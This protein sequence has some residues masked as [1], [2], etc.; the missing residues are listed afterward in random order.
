MNK[1]IFGNGGITGISD[2]KFS[3][4]RG[5]AHRLVG[6]DY[7][8]EPGIVKVQQAL[9]DTS[10]LNEFCKIGVN[11]PDNSRLWFSSTS[12]KIWRDVND[13]F[14]LVHTMSPITDF[15]EPNSVTSVFD[16]S[17]IENGISLSISEN[18]FN[19]G[20]ISTPVTSVIDAVRGRDNSIINLDDNIMVLA[21]Q[22]PDS[23]G[24]LKSFQFTSTG[25]LTVIETLEHDTLNS[26]YNSICRIDNTHYMLAYK[27][28]Y[29]RAIIKTF[30]GPYT[31][32]QLSSLEH[33]GADV[34]GVYN[35]LIQI[36]ATHYAL[37]YSKGPAGH[38]CIKIFTIDGAYA[39][40]Q[41]SQLIHDATGTTYGHSLV[42]IDS[43][44]LMLSYVNSSYDQ[45]IKTF[46]ID[47]AWNVTQ[48]NSKNH[49]N[50]A[51]SLLGSIV[52]IDPTHYAWSGRMSI[53]GYVKVFTINGSYVITE[54]FSKD[55]KLNNNYPVLVK[56]DD[57][58]ITLFGSGTNSVG[59]IK[60]FEI[61]DSFE[62]RE[63]SS[64]AYTSNP[65][66]SQASVARLGRYLAV[67][68]SDL[69]VAN[70]ASRITANETYSN[71]MVLKP[72]GTSDIKL[73]TSKFYTQS[74]MADRYLKETI[75]IPNGYSNLDV[76]VIAG[77]AGSE[78]LPP[79]GA[80]INGVAMTQVYNRSS[81]GGFKCTSS[82]FNKVN[83]S[84]GDNEIIVDFGSQATYTY[85]AVLVFKNVHQT[86]P[87][88]ANTDYGWKDYLELTGTTNGELK[89]GAFLTK[90]NT[91]SHGD[92][93][94]EIGYID[95]AEDSDRYTL[96]VGTR[97]YN[98]GTAKILSADYFAYNQMESVG[99]EDEE[100]KPQEQIGKIYYTN[101]NVLFAVPLDKVTDWANNI[102]TVGTFFNGDDTYHPMQKQNLEL[103][104]GD[105]NVISKVNSDGDFIQLT[106]F[107]VSD[108]ER[109]QT[110]SRFD[111]DLLIGT[112][113]INKA[114]VKRW[115]TF[116]D[117]WLAEDD[118][119]ETGINAFIKDD[120]FTYVSAG[121]F[122][123]IYFYNGEKLTLTKRIPGEWGS[124]KKAIVNPNATN[125]YMGTPVF[126]LSNSTGNPALQ[127][128][129]GFGAYDE[130]YIK[131]LSLDFPVPTK[132][133]SG[134]QIGAILVNGAD[135]YVS[136][137]TA[138][139][140]GAIAKLNHSKKYESAYIETMV[141]IPNED[142]NDDNF[143]EG[144]CADYISLPADTD[145][146]IGIK[147]KYDTTYTDL[148][149]ITDTKR[150]SIRT[151]PIPKVVNLQIKFS[152]TTDAN[153]APEVENFGIL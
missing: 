108:P 76:V 49:G 73:V 103:F 65:I 93:Q 12:G 43:T 77:R 32:S 6:I 36:D 56:S 25:A 152:F 116:S 54:T 119:F 45:I 71:G 100:Y 47:G 17:E 22:G 87:Y 144:I 130:K 28:Q 106:P 132:E 85:M 127:G 57:N 136:Y 38:A 39:I 133:L 15:K 23:D 92:L 125:F 141:T 55:I 121:D 98:I 74:S 96:S 140:T 10:V 117:S 138:T 113:D 50:G 153:N 9:S 33:D 90:S 18:N 52:Q 101:E 143:I 70:Y 151:K 27:G 81:A 102:E 89:L 137:K 21:Y 110:L 94:N 44:H 148:T 78:L 118:V 80:T 19:Y 147:T 115:D 75:K 91:H 4:I 149:T 134:V 34:S 62:L 120:N 1:P 16:D 122:G 146:D 11:L 51:G 24:F 67:V 131:G 83:P 104:I 68:F 84:T 112:K 48:V 26:E 79:T 97:K 5:N 59:T 8:S 2:S 13:V 58:H 142:R 63:T 37:A 20:R 99:T 46:A 41:T 14:T 109:I 61:T 139:V 126:G 31:F 53:R 129:Y 7:K 40:S 114:N 123:N 69:G 88:S 66:R 72:S 86:T 95:I 64:D 60:T 145:I 29:S 30:S 128:V 107:N 3:G 42:K 111:T 124:T 35:S 105:K 82:F 150:M 135:M